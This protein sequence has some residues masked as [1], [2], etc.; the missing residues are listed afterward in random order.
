M[1][2]DFGSGCTD[3]KGVTRSGLIRAIY[4]GAYRQTGSI[5]VIHPF[6]YTRDGNSIDGTKTVANKGPNAEGHIEYSVKIRDGKLTS[7]EGTISWESDRNRK[8]IKGSDTPWPN[9][10]DDVYE[11]TGNGKGKDI[12]GYDFSVEI[13]TPLRVE[14]SCRW[15]V[16]GTLELIHNRADSY[17]LNYGNG[18]CDNKAVFTVRKKEYDVVLR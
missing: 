11:V 7:P 16:S 4:K 2:V 9:W 13:K 1:L 12:N 5:I 17:S 14:L 6:D 10:I 3:V 18:T 15:I 8:W